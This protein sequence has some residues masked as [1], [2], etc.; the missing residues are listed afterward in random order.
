MERVCGAPFREYSKGA[1]AIGWRDILGPDVSLKGA[2]TAPLDCLALIRVSLRRGALS[3]RGLGWRGYAEIFLRRLLF[4]ANNCA[5]FGVRIGHGTFSQ[6]IH[7]PWRD[8]EFRRLDLEGYSKWPCVIGYCA[9]DGLCPVRLYVDGPEG[10]Y[11][12]IAAGYAG[13]AA[14]YKRDYERTCPP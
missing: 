9:W 7:A 3:A 10:R 14:G 5:A 13:I 1:W 11:S 12:R 6:A 8:E 4:W 2:S